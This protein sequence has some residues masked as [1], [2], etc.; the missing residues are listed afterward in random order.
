[1]ILKLNFMIRLILLFLSLGFL[2]CKQ[3]EVKIDY[4]RI[5][6]YGSMT[7]TEATYGISTH[8]AIKMVFD[9]VNEDGG[10]NGK[11]IKLISYDDQG[12]AEE[13]AIAVTRLIIQDK[14][15]VVMGEVASSR[16]LA[17]AIIAQRYRVPM[18]T[19]S[20]TNP[21]VTKQGNFIFRVCFTDSFQGKVLAKFALERL[22]AKKV[23]VFVDKKSD[24]SV[25][26]AD[27]FKKAFVSQGGRIVIVENYVGGDIDFNGQLTA[28]K[29]KEPDLIVLPGYYTEAGLILK[30]ARALGITQ[31]FLGGD[32]LDSSKLVEIGGRAM[33]GVYFSTHFSPDDKDP[34][35]QNFIRK[36]KALYKEVPDAMAVLAYDAAQVLVA[37]IARSPSLGGEDLRDAIAMTKD[38]QGVTGKITLDRDRNAMK[39][40]V[41]VQVS[42]GAFKFVGRF[43]P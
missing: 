38:F 20:S 32:G 40:A 9:Q 42:K 41:V 15:H 16:S 1:M 33:E 34:A 5:G 8:R 35:I 11:Q 39:E 37:A 43:K 26:L 22:K 30:Q 29:A 7:G 36:F 18:I 13:A 24:Y 17:G 10:I 27:V 3:A 6:E 4:I 14:V 23:A 21:A 19:P 2:A 12:K 31:P 25:G 28:I